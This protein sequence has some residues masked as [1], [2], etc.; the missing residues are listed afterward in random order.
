[1]IQKPRS[2]V[3]RIVISAF[4]LAMALGTTISRADAETERAEL[5]RL[6]HE[7]ENLESL[8]EQ[9]EAAAVST[10]RVHFQYAWLRGD[11]EKIKAGI[12]E[13]L[14]TV[15]ATPRIP[16]ALAGDYIR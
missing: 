14:D 5:S 3:C 1:M 7:L 4:A 13:Y 9:S 15:P 12:R 11:L 10:Q 8:I 2:T 6:I 16:P